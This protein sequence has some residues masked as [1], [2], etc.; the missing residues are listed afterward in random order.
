MLQPYNLV[1]TI[2]HL[3]GREERVVTVEANDPAQAMDLALH[4]TR[5]KVLRGLPSGRDPYASRDVPPIS[6][7]RA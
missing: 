5:A 1:V 4:S 7:R 3:D 2:E 6:V